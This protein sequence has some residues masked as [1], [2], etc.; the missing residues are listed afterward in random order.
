MAFGTES[1]PCVNKIF[2]PGNQ[3]VTKAKEMVQLDGIAIDLPAGPSEI[4]II[5][6]NTS[7]ASFIAADLLSQAEHGNDSQV[8]LL[9]DSEGLID[10]VFK[11]IV[12]QI[13]KLPRKSIASA[14]LDNSLSIVFSTMEQ[15]IEFSNKYAPEHLVIA[16]SDPESLAEKV[17][18]AGSVFIGKYSCESIGDYASGTNHTLP[19]GGFARTYGGV[20]VDSF[21]RKITFQHVGRNGIKSLGP[22]VMTMAE[23]ENLSG[24]SKAISIRLKNI[25]NEKHR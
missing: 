16:T 17:I 7:D 11:E 10:S 13:N 24:H 22:V 2:G 25:D 20:S 12:Q 9:T 21:V 8:I 3:Y 18:N 1:I 14:A 23:A 15:C 5:G 19:T 6:D 4:L